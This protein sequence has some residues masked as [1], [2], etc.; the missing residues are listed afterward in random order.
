[1]RSDSSHLRLF[2]GDLFLR[3]KKIEHTIQQILS[4]EER[5]FNLLKFDLETISVENLVMQARSFPMLGRAQV[6]LVRSFERLKKENVLLLEAYFEN[7][8]EWSYFFFESDQVEENHPL[9]KLI[10]RFGERFD[11]APNDRKTG[12][13]FIHQKLKS[14]GQTITKEAWQFLEEKTG[15]D[16]TLLDACIEKLMLYWDQEKPIDV[17]PARKLVDEFLRF[18]TFDLTEAICE[19]NPSKAL[20]VFRYLYELEGTAV[21]VIGLLNWQLKR[22]WQAKIL[23]QERGEREMLKFLR[24][25]PYRVPTFLKQVA[26]FSFHTLEQ[27]ISQL[28]QIDWKLKTGQMNEQIVLEAFIVKLATSE[29]SLLRTA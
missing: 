6:F 10:T 16:F 11:C 29:K 24:I 2:V 21:P 15:G 22:I 19:K 20:Q 25:S 9:L 3:K 7:P 17:E 27:A 5:A 18:D 14:G 1:M 8:T 23:T 26:R 13:D 4:S 28:F 12:I